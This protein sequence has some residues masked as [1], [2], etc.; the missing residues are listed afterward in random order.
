M[1]ADTRFAA[2]LRALAAALNEIPAPSMI[3]GGIAVIAAGVP[4]ETVDIDAAILGRDVTAERVIAILGRHDITPRID[5][6][7]SF[8]RDRQVLL[9]RHEPTGVTI[10]ISFA[11]LPFEEEALARAI[12]TDVEGM[13]VRLAT[14]EDLIVYKTTAWRDRDRSDIERLF[15]LHF[16]EI[17]LDRVRALVREISAV[18]DDPERIVEFDRIVERARRAR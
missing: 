9:L 6:A 8:V 10:E 3:I 16:D 17:D 4:R 12:E 18:L 13:K 7:L 15:V 11:W 2:A 14:P 1:T 5:D